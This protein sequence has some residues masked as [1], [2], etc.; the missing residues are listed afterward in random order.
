MAAEQSPTELHSTT[1]TL[2][3]TEI[4]KVCLY[5]KSLTAPGLTFLPGPS[6]MSPLSSS[7]ATRKSSRHMDRL[8]SE[9]ILT[10]A[11]PISSGGNTNSKEQ[12]RRPRKKS[13]GQNVANSKEVEGKEGQLMEMPVEILLE[14]FGQVDPIDLLYISWT[15]KDLRNFVRSSNTVWNLVRVQ[16]RCSCRASWCNFNFRLMRIW[17]F[18]SAHPCVRTTSTLVSTPIISLEIDVRCAASQVRLSNY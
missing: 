18:T 8:K 3:I 10:E 5:L 13:K 9:S 17:L 2:F 14:I 1:S 6:L 7:M 11:S 15:S 12:G 4:G 16:S